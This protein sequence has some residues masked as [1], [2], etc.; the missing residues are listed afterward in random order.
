[1][2]LSVSATPHPQV[3][4]HGERIDEDRRKATLAGESLNNPRNKPDT[5]DVTQ[6][7]GASAEEEFSGMRSR[8]PLAG[9]LSVVNTLRRRIPPTPFEES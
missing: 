5:S 6:V 7:G 2:V 9:G 4:T 8:P 3:V 1:L